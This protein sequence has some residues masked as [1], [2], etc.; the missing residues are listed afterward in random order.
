[1]AGSGATLCRIYFPRV[2][3]FRT[4]KIAFFPVASYHFKAATD[5]L[6]NGLS[7]LLVFLRYLILCSFPQ[8]WV[9]KKKRKKERKKEKEKEKSEGTRGRRRGWTADRGGRL[10]REKEISVHGAK[11]NQISENRGKLRA[12]EIQ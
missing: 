7:D 8:A 10:G 6:F 11:A 2:F 3:S 5:V 12:I 4:N 1:V 9:I